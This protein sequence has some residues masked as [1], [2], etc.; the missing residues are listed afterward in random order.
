MIH[1][2]PFSH[3]FP[4]G[5]NRTLI[6]FRGALHPA[7]VNIR[8]HGCG[9]HHIFKGKFGTANGNIN[10]AIVEYFTENAN[11]FIFRPEDVLQLGG[12]TGFSSQE[13]CDQYQ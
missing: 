5:G 7:A 9:I 12:V 8:L 1:C 13:V 4:F 3:S 10:G 11:A 2:Q 6:F